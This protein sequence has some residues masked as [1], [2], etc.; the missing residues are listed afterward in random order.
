MSLHQ[1]NIFESAKQLSEVMTELRFMTGAF[2]LEEE[3]VLSKTDAD[4][5]IVLSLK[6]LGEK[7]ER[8]QLMATSIND[9]RSGK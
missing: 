5:I 8:L 1:E 2:A 9:A 4:Q 7:S 3:G 6:S